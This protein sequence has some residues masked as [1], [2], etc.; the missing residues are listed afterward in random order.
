MN[1]QLVLDKH[2]LFFKAHHTKSYEFRLD[3]L[4][5][6]KEA[7]L[8]YEEEIKDA[9][10]K[11]L[12]K[13]EFES[14]LT[15]IGITILEINEV[16]KNLKR[17]MKPKKVKTP[18]TLFHAKS[19]IYQ[20]PYG[21]V[22][23]MSPWN[24]PFQ[25]AISPLI[26]VIAAGNTAI[27]KMSHDSPETSKVIHKMISEI[28]PDDFV[29]VFTGGLEESKALL[30]LKYDYIFFTGSTAVGKIVMSEASKNLIPV[31]LELGGK[32]PAIIDETVDLD[33]TAKRI[34]YGKFINAGQ[35]CIAPDY[36]LIKEELKNE[37]LKQIKKHI[38]SWFG[39]DPLSHPD[40]PK[41]INEKNH[42]RLL[43][44]IENETVLLGGGFNKDKIEPTILNHIT[45]NSRVMHEEIFG[46]ILPLITYKND[47]ELITEIEWFEK[48][49]AL[50]L[51]T[52]NKNLEKKIIEE[53]SFGGA[54]INDTL[55]H[56]GNKNIPFGGVG[57]SGMGSYHGYKSFETFS[58][59]KGVVKRST[60]I[61]LDFRYPPYTKK[62]L[63][64]LKK[65]IK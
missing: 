5:R 50:Y 63:G 55:M 44:L 62:K 36:I 15:E 19:Y 2:H 61:D 35:T 56:F 48:P 21:T 64:L 7:I 9:L 43:S 8:T 59:A 47:D 45:R 13:S 22:F 17:W 24:Y 18:I 20:E 58:H 51:F 49:L 42:Q 39:E 30:K 28:F 57:S 37:F 53:L 41:I 23:I 25:L 10:K 40:Y 32:S 38:E 34:A 1:Y 27:I 29:S 60:V 46:P 12:N 31:T 11:D 26:G 65:F 14:F 3:A 16:M 33:L 4:K 6:L 54:T 52:K